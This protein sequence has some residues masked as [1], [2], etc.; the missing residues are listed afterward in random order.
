MK[1]LQFRKMP[2][3][4][5]LATVTLLKDKWYSP[6]TQALF[7]LVVI[8]PLLA[9]QGNGGGGGGGGYVKCCYLFVPYSLISVHSLSTVLFHVSFGC[10]HFLF[11]FGAQVKPKNHHHLWVLAWFPVWNT[12]TDP[13]FIKGGGWYPRGCSFNGACSLIVAV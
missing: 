3:N 6:V 8:F 12:G 13:E 11:P 9:P 4:Q 7:V 1:S 2:L 10:S 5:N